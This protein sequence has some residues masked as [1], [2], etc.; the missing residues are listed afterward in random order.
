MSFKELL[1]RVKDLP[2]SDRLRLLR[3]L[4][5]EF[6][7]EEGVPSLQDSQPYAVWTPY[8]ATDAAAVLLKCL[9]EDREVKKA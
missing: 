2:R 1:P 7:R 6:A 4:V 3:F 9:E 8:E 5:D